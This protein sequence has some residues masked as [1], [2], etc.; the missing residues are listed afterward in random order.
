M[1]NEA[2]KKPNSD[3]A[4]FRSQ[5]IDLEVKRV[6]QAIY[7]EFDTRDPDSQEYQHSE[8]DLKEIQEREWN[9]FVKKYPEKAEAYKGQNRLIQEALD[10]QNLE[11]NAGTQPASTAAPEPLPVVKTPEEL[12]IEKEEVKRIKKQAAAEKKAIADI[13][14]RLKGI[15]SESLEWEHASMPVDLEYV[16]L[17]PNLDEENELKRE[18]SEAEIYAKTQAEEEIEYKEALEMHTASPEKVVVSDE[19]LET[20]E[21]GNTSE[22]PESKENTAASDTP[23]S[24]EKENASG[25]GNEK[26]KISKEVLKGM[27]II[28]ATVGTVGAF[29]SAAT[30]GGLVSSGILN[31][32]GLAPSVAP[33]IFNAGLATATLGAVGWAASF[34][35]ADVF[36]LSFARNLWV[37]GSAWVKKLTGGVFAGGSGGKG[38]SAPKAAHAP[39]GGGHGG[40]H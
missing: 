23:K 22:A 20:N 12:K 19:A 4:I 28:G 38:G 24:I 9:A 34:V 8:A 17:E 37:E 7:R 6:R 15:G 10:R 3:K 33:V 36:W 30:V 25:K 13:Q 18:K 35:L 32:F 2:P 27:R 1:S 39:S 14:K 21:R 26:K 16:P 5:N 40:G 11:S 29:A 31:S